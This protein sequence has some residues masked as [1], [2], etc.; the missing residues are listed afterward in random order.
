MRSVCCIT[1]L[2]GVASTS[3]EVTPIEKVITLIEGLKKEVVTEGKS[4]A[5]AYAKFACFC[6]KNTKKESKEIIKGNDKI[7]VLSADLKS[8]TQ[9]KKV[10]QSENSKRSKKG[11]A[12]TRALASEVSQCRRDQAEYEKNAADMSKAVSSL[13]GAIKSTRTSKPKNAFIQ[14]REVADRSPVTKQLVD[15]FLQRAKVDPSDPE[16]DYHSNDIIELMQGLLKDFRG[17]KSNLDKSWKARK[18]A[19]GKIQKAY[20]KSLLSNKDAMNQNKKDIQKVGQK[21]AGDREKMVGTKSTLKDDKRYL[22]A[23]TTSCEARAVEWDQRSKQRNDEINSLSA[24][25]KI[26]GVR[27]KSAD[28]VNKRAFVQKGSFLQV[29]RSISPQALGAL[30]ELQ[31]TGRRLSSM[32]LL[33][34]VVRARAGPFDKLKGLIDDLVERLVSESEAEATKKGWCDTA[35]AKA[36]HSRDARYGESQDLNSDVAGLEA[37]EDELKEEAHTLAK[38]IKEN[39]RVKKDAIATRK[40]E[41]DGNAKTIQVAKEG[42]EATTE[43]ITLLQKFY[44][45]AA[46]AASFLQE[47]APYGLPEAKGAYQGKQTG[48][49]AVTDLLEV[50]QSDFERTIRSTESADATAARD[51]EKMMQTLKADTAGK[52]TGLMMDKQD[53]KSG[54]LK[55]RTKSADLKSNVNLLDGALKEIENLKPACIDTGMSYKERVQKREEEM[56]SLQKALKMLS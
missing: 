33:S 39:N 17:K 51:Y 50:I 55:I 14:V 38:G 40:E 32:A 37:K 26:L 41:K 56:A 36:K 24:A 12:M 19:C 28:K 49:K 52:E 27:V 31:S 34:M 20:Q 18:G 54:A 35:V 8:E 48:M 9:T 42:L 30:E 1:L 5:A 25:L 21:I 11:E 22:A 2:L 53:I 46:K 4:E 44:S 13:V 43:A 16:Y 47:D 7:G 45:E 6:K 15:S 3:L 29:K 10:E 23:V